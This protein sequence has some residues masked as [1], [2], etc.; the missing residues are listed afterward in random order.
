MTTPYNIPTAD[1]DLEYPCGDCQMYRGGA[2]A[3]LDC[4]V[5]MRWHI[6]TGSGEPDDYCP[7]CDDFHHDKFYILSICPVC[8]GALEHIEKVTQ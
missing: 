3:C 7:E 4:P 1:I 5:M 6:L 2:D 8:G